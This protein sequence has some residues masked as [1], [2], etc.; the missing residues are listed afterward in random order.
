MGSEYAPL[1]SVLAVLHCVNSVS[2][3]VIAFVVSRYELEKCLAIIQ[4]TVDK[5][6]SILFCEV[7]RLNAKLVV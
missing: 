1:V 2:K 6:A 7:I 5:K 3:Y 4:F